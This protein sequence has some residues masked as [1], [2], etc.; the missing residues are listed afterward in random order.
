MNELHFAFRVRQLLNRSLQQ[1]DDDKLA[2]LKAAR[3]AALAVQKKPA[4]VPA[5]A[6]A[7]HFI[8]FNFDNRGIRF[9]LAA[10]ALILAGALY[11]H[12][13]ADQ[14]INEL[15]DVDSALLADDMP[16]DALIDKDFDEWLKKSREH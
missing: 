11:V 1:V 7:G 14:L 8:R 13:Q 5:L 15:S 9:S 10:L 6:A 12:W 3:E 2:R 4:P 16:V